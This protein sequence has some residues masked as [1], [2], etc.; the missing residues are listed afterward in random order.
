MQ[1]NV[2]ISVAAGLLSAVFFLSTKWSFLGALIFTLFAPLPLLAAGLGLGLAA[3]ASAAL[4]ATITVALIANPAGTAVFAI[5]YGVPPLMLVHFSLL[6]RKADDGTTEWYPPGPLL[7]WIA[8]FG[9][10]TFT[11]VAVFAGVEDLRAGISGYVD[12]MRGLI[13]RSDQNSPGADR[14]FDTVKLIFPFIIMT[15]W[16]IVTVVN[17]VIAQRM[18]ERRGWSKRPA[19]DLRTTALPPW[20]LGVMVAAMVAALLGSDWLGFIGINVALSLCIPYFFVGLAVLHA[21]SAPWPS[22]KAILFAAYTLLL[23]FSWTALVVA[24]IGFLE[25]WT[26]LRERFGGPNRSHERKE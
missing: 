7:A 4:T 2:L 13:V 22:R 26:G 24:G 10:C 25:Y 20:L 11:A 18:L 9:V 15:W 3:A 17:G 8:L 23:F 16:M 12:T 21:I 1:R 6:N 19:P 5:A 14:I